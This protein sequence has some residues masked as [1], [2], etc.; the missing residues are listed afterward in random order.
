MAILDSIYKYAVYNKIIPP[1]TKKEDV[2]KKL[3][4][5]YYQHSVNRKLKGNP[6]RLTFEDWLWWWGPDIFNIGAESNRLCM[7]RY[8]DS[9]DYKFANIYKATGKENSQHYYTQQ[10]PHKPKFRL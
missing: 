5:K 2:E 6:M 7:C 1:T 3:K 4:R 8:G 10:Y 9:G